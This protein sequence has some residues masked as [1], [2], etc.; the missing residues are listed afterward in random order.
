MVVRHVHLQLLVRVLISHSGRGGSRG[1]RLARRSGGLGCGDLVLGVVLDKLEERLERAVTL[2][3]DELLGASGLELKSREA[4]N[5][6]SSRLG[7]VISGGVHLE[8]DG[9]VS[10]SQNREYVERTW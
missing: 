6:D 1:R 5:L 7:E 2:I 10:N 3:V 8:T 4:S 9:M